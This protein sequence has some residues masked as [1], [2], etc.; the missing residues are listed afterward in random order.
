MGTCMHVKPSQMVETEIRGCRQ[1]RFAKTYGQTSGSPRARNLSI[2]PRTISV[3]TTGSRVPLQSQHTQSAGLFLKALLQRFLVIAML[4][5]QGLISHFLT[6]SASG[7]NN[8][9][10]SCRQLI[11]QEISQVSVDTSNMNIHTYNNLV[12]ISTYKIPKNHYS[13]PHTVFKVLTE[14]KIHERASNVHKIII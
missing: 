11:P 13:Q 7:Y 10:K 12:L 9:L 2:R 14:I 1:Q 5:V 3:S 6:L 8:N 4:I